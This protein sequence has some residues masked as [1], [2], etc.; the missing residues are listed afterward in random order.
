[1][2]PTNESTQSKV[3]HDLENH[4][5]RL[6]VMLK[7]LRDKDLDGIDGETFLNDSKTSLKAIDEGFR[8][9]VDSESILVK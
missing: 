3:Y 5:L 4:L 7:L 2:N 6:K 9:L 8:N 1:M